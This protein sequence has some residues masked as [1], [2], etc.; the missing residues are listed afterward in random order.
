MDNSQQFVADCLESLARNNPEPWALKQLIKRLQQAK[1][2]KR[3]HK[4]RKKGPPAGLHGA[5]LCKW[6]MAHTPGI[7]NLRYQDYLQTEYWQAVRELKLRNSSGRC[8]YCGSTENIRIHHE[9]Y[10][11]KYCEYDHLDE[12]S[13]VCDSCHKGVHGIQSR[14]QWDNARQKAKE[15]VSD[16]NDRPQS[17]TGDTVITTAGPRD[18]GLIRISRCR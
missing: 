15:R 13:V 12:L 1:K 11:H 3:E 5:E 7:R 16:A 18:Q 14:Q 2:Y 17:T 4:R 6:W 8:E 9:S 10:T